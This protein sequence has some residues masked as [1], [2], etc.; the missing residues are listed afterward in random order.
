MTAFLKIDRCTSCRQETPWEWVPPVLLR[1][2]P[3]AG[4]GVWRSALIDG[5]CPR[6]ADARERA[7]QRERHVQTL[8]E[9]FIRMVGG[10]KPY[11]DFT[12]EKYQVTREN[13]LAFQRARAFDP[14]RDN[15]YLW[16][17]CGVGKTHL[18]VAILR[19]WFG[20]GASGALVTPFKLIRKLRM[21]P[22][23]EEQLAIDGFIGV[24]VLVIDDLGVGSDT[25]Y[26]RQ[27]LQEILDGRS[28]SDR[29]GLVVTSPYSLL[30]LARRLNDR[31]ISSRL[32]GLCRVV[33]IQGPDH[34]SIPKAT[35]GQAPRTKQC[36]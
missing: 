14:S 6:C 15:L 25:V 36:S 1:G 4:T 7:R 9:Q 3:L 18:A 23:D 32:G 20:R 10:V 21:K 27:I 16:G 17:P 24:G 30:G 19:Q 22:P 34:R 2:E 28:F 29:A 31:T 13:R 26:A 5:L 35:G 8:R 33:E 12:F 11:R